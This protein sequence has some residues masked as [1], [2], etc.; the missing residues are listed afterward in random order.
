MTAKRAISERAIC[1]F[2]PLFSYIPEIRLDIEYCMELPGANNRYNTRSMDHAIA[3]DIS[4]NESEP[5]TLIVKI[6][7]AA[8]KWRPQLLVSV[9]SPIKL[10]YF[11]ITLSLPADK[12]QDII[13]L[14]CNIEY[15]HLAK[16]KQAQ[17]ERAV[18]KWQPSEAMTPVQLE[19]AIMNRLLYLDWSIVFTATYEAPQP[20]PNE[21]EWF[22]MDLVGGKDNPARFRFL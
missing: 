8:C 4:I 13:G 10:I 17:K 1:K 21:F 11:P 6:E 2:K 22:G 7:G 18:V 15:L 16:L 20:D 3:G 5:E 9:I 19:L 12:I 14:C